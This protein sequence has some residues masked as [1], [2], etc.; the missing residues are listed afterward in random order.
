MTKILITG[1]TGVLGRVLTPK[2]VERGHSV[3]IMSR[4]PRPANLAANL[5]W[6]QAQLET[7]EGLEAAVRGVPVIIHCASSPLKR[8]READVDGT[9]R[10]LKVAQAAGV[11]HFIYISIVGIERFPTYAYYKIKLAVEQLIEAS[12]VPYTI[13]RATQ[14]HELLDR[15]LQ[16]AARWPMLF[17]PKD[18]QFQLVDTGTVAKALAE[19]VAT[20]P[21]GRA[22]DVGGPEILLSGEII[23]AWLAARGLRRLVLPLSLPFQAAEGFRRGYNTCPQNRQGTLTW[24]AWLNQKYRGQDVHA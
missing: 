8:T 14:F 7:G 23:A 20:G 22:A 11:Q 9:A 4:G 16:G 19:C 5:E 2:L 15:V 1:G 24:A 10:L 6:A 13:L 3:R 12:G 18:L 17:L 21:A